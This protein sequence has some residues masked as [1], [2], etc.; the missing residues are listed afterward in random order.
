MLLSI[1]VELYFFIAFFLLSL[2]PT[3]KQKLI[4]SFVVFTL[5]MLDMR[6]ANLI[7]VYLWSSISNYSSGCA[8]NSQKIQPS[9][10]DL[11]K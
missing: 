8:D 1:H 2:L 7:D 11:G 6:P 5:K 3:F 10:S 4:F 9:G